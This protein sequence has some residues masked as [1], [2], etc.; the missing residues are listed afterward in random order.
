MCIRDRST[1]PSGAMW[2]RTPTSIAAAGDHGGPSYEARV[3]FDTPDATADT[4]LERA[5]GYVGSF[6]VFGHGGCFSEHGHCDVRGPV[7]EHGERPDVAGGAF[8]RSVRRRIWGV[9]EDPRLVRRPAVV[10]G[11]RDR[12]G[13]APPHSARRRRAPVSYTHPEPTRLGMI[14]YAVFCL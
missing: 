9:E 3:F 10:A 8:Q 7:T 6:T 5:A 2:R 4:P 13:R 14:S 1:P 11:R 12:S